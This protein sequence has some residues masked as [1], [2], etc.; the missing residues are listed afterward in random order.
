MKKLFALLKKSGKTSYI[1]LAMAGFLLAIFFFRL[2]LLSLIYSS[3]ILKQEPNIPKLTYGIILSG[4]AKDRAHFAAQLFHQ[5]KVDTLICLGENIP[6]DLKLMGLDYS[7]SQITRQALIQNSVPDSHI[8]TI[9]KGHSTISEIQFIKDQEVF[10]TTSIGIISSQIHTRRIKQSM[11]SVKFK[12][13]NAY[14]LGCPSSKIHKDNW[15]KEEDGL[16]SVS[17]EWQ[18]LIYYLFTY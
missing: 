11:N 18:K 1:L 12:N 16:I 10:N 17:T 15:W 7:E 2:P 5:Q 3:L 9:E 8:K 6:N 13:K 14:I 4:N